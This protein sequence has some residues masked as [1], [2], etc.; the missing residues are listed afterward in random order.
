MLGRSKSLETLKNSFQNEDL[1]TVFSDDVLKLLSTKSDAGIFPPYVPFLGKLFDEYGIL[2]YCTAQNIPHNCGLVKLYSDNFDKL[3]C[4][5]EYGGDFKRHY[6]D[7]DFEIGD[8]DIAPFE[9]GVIPA[10]IA[11]FIYAQKGIQISRE[12][13][14]DYCGVTNYYKF[15]LHSKSKD[16]NPD[17]EMSQ[18]KPQDM[19]RYWA[20]NDKFVRQEL[21]AIRPKH[22]IS[23]NGYKLRMLA[24]Y[25][26]DFNYML[27]SV[28]DPSWILRGAS[29]KLKP[30]DDWGEELQKLDEGTAEF[31]TSYVP[32]LKGGYAGK[33][34]AVKAYLAHYY[35]FFKQGENGK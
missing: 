7:T 8:V 22:V 9:D 18:L 21:E 35:N 28:N 15:S 14:L 29:G 32:I 23:F 26:T 24:S 31:I 4:R 34:E 20:I 13:I 3:S 2:V 12:N 1:N 25:S 16:I 33:A 5:L 30:D 17:G 6:G 27:H 19:Y 11:V 10:L